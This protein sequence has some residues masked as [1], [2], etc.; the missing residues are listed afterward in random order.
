MSQADPR[1]VSDLL[2]VA[3]DLLIGLGAA[4]G[5]AGQHRAGTG[6]RIPDA[7]LDPSDQ[8]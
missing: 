7:G 3:R 8:W 4:I 5:A 6:D 1:I 2:A